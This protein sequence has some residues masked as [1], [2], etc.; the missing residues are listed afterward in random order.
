MSNDEMPATVQIH[1]IKSHHFRSV[2]VDGVLGG[3]TPNGSIHLAVFSERSPIPQKAEMK[4]TEGR[5]GDTVHS[6][7]K[8]GI[9]RE[10]DV[11][12][13][14]NLPVARELRDWLSTRI[15]ELETALKKGTKS[16]E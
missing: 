1:Y 12:L 2:H 11:D 9:V 13:F 3:V 6:E 8:E 4:I 5:L 16:N 7:G 10:M 15:Q 14:M